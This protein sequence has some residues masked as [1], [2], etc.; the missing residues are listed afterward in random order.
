MWGGA[1]DIT[2]GGILIALG[3]AI[4][5]LTTII[6]INTI[7]LLT[8]CSCLIPIAI[9]R[10]NLKTAFFVYIS[11]SIISFFIVPINY[12]LLYTLFFGIYG[13]IKFFIEKTGKLFIE[14]I[15]KI[16]Y[17]NLILGFALFFLD[18]ILPSIEIN[19]H[20]GLL[21]CISQVAFIIY[22]YAMTIFVTYFLEKINKKLP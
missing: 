4:L 19:I 16:L 18:K 2:L 9:I 8:L 5:Y 10:S 15:L 20:T 21:L 7:A 17:F 22:D 12:A 13:I 3:I 11:T 6:N 1:R 14:L